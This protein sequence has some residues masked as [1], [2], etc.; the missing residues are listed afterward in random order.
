VPP[1]RPPEVNPTK[2]VMLCGPPATFVK[3]TVAPAGMVIV[4]GSN[5]AR[6]LPLPVILT[7]TTGPLDV[8][9][10]GAAGGGVWVCV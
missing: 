3:R 4:L 1:R 5:P 8:A 9:A 2:N 6:V 7:S 10:V